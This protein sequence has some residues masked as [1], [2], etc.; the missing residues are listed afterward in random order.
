MHEYWKGNN[1]GGALLIQNWFRS[2]R[3]R[4]ASPFVRR[5]R[6]VRAALMF[7]SLWRGHETRKFYAFKKKLFNEKASRIQ[8]FWRGWS[9]RM[10]WRGIAR[11]IMQRQMEKMRKVKA[12][13]LVLQN[14]RTNVAKERVVQ[15]EAAEKIAR[16]YKRHLREVKGHRAIV[17]EREKVAHNTKVFRDL[18]DIAMWRSKAYRIK[19]AMFPKYFPP[20]PP[21]EFGKIDG[22]TREEL[23]LAREE[24]RKSEA[25]LS[26]AIS[27]NN[28]LRAE[29]KKY[30]TMRRKIQ[31]GR[32]H[33]VDRL[34]KY[35]TSL[36]D[37]LQAT[38]ELYEMHYNPTVL[39]VNQLEDSVLNLLRVANNM[40]K[41]L[42]VFDHI[43]VRRLQ[44]KTTRSIRKLL[45]FQYLDRNEFEKLI[46]ELKIAN[47]EDG[48][49]ICIEGEEGNDF[50]IMVDGEVTV[51]QWSEDEQ[52]DVEIVTLG[53]GATFGE[54]A[55]LR[56]DGKRTASVIAKGDVR[57]FTLDRRKFRALL[58]SRSLQVL[59][60]E[61][62]KFD[63]ENK[64]KTTK[65][66]DSSKEDLDL[67]RYG[68]HVSEQ[69][70]ELQKLADLRSQL[71]E[72]RRQAQRMEEEEKRLSD[73]RAREHERIRSH[74]LYAES[75]V[76]VEKAVAF[77][78]NMRTRRANIKSSA[79]KTTEQSIRQ[80]M[81]K[82]W[83]Q[84]QKSKSQ[85]DIQEDELIRHMAAIRVQATWRKKQGTYTSF[86]IKR[87]K[88]QLAEEAKINEMEGRAT[89]V[90]LLRVSDGNLT[91]LANQEGLLSTWESDLIARAMDDGSMTLRSLDSRDAVSLGS[92][93]SGMD[94]E[95]RAV[96]S[97]LEYDLLVM[98]TGRM[99]RMGLFEEE[100]D[101]EFEALE[102]MLQQELMEDEEYR[103]W[104]P[105]TRQSP[106]DVL[107][108]L[109]NE[110]RN[111]NTE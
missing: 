7:E 12:M 10:R 4:L 56:L 38:G 16:Y 19:S 52:R 39:Q 50:Y 32:Q 51:Y 70:K 108:G 63:K 107:Q 8:R 42:G 83:F 22:T 95:D 69:D 20:P 76:V 67:D 80:T 3:K 89:R 6:Q 104:D 74:P 98:E 44:L 53:M 57:A 41:E 86:V 26:E 40:F 11:K 75:S 100:M 46:D 102:A 34:H 78:M 96:F 77:A 48:D 111:G 45:P 54:M 62:N 25:E 66:S 2:Q 60:Y 92:V 1:I 13:N 87:A 15:H 27:Y 72:A 5:R 64:K 30:H 101:A 88:Q 14:S 65:L 103:N 106:R 21:S 47:F 31:S 36:M 109:M 59:E 24:L 33:V 110:N 37:E 79:L 58:S 85:R 61:L 35:E 29:T 68:M 49:A 17:A 99:L 105:A 55:L 81:R 9:A 93:A 97:C 82:I 28:M 91:N 84:L 23:Y 94:D 43:D 18:E 73:I 90:P 71:I